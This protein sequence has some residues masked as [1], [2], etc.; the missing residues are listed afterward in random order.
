[1]LGLIQRHVG[2]LEHVGDRLAFV[3]QRRQPDRDRDVDPLGALVDRKVSPAIERR[4][5]SA[6]MPATVRSVSGITITNS[7]P[8]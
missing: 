6:T 1:V 5:R 2:A 7:S 8:P 3:V 4:R